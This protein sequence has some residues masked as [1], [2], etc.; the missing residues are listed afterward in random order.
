MKILESSY[1]EQVFSQDFFLFVQIFF[2]S[3]KGFF[4]RTNIIFVCSSKILLVLYK[5]FLLMQ[6]FLKFAKN[7]R[8]FCKIFVNI[9]DR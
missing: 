9:H 8:K 3:G 5:H 4:V 7:L 1:E 2:C 6:I